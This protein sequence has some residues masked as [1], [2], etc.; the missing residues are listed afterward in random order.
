MYDH[1]LCVRHCAEVC[2][3]EEAT[4]VGPCILVA[5]SLNNDDNVLT[6]PPAAIYNELHR[7]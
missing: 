1:L 3:N 2:A 6:H 7:K 5:L 4:W